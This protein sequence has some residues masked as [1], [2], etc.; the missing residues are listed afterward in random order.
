[1]QITLYAVFLSPSDPAADCTEGGKKDAAFPSVDSDTSREDSVAKMV[2]E[3]MIGRTSARRRGHT[4]GR[5]LSS[6]VSLDA[7]DEETHG[8]SSSVGTV[9]ATGEESEKVCPGSLLRHLMSLSSPKDRKIRMN[10]GTLK[11]MFI[12]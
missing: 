4:N 1:M 2:V 10:L 6:Q 12:K 7:D 11:T 9:E 3:R 8:R 5:L